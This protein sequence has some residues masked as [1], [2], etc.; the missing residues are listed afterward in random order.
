MATTSTIVQANST[1]PVK[2]PVIPLIIAVVLGVL[3]SVSA[4]SGLGYYLI[5]SGKL[6]LQTASSVQAAPAVSTKTYAVALE[7]MVVNLAD[8]SSGAY[9]RLSMTL[10]VADAADQPAKEEKSANKQADAALR[11]TAL[12]VLVRQTSE[13]LLAADGK[14]QL[15]KE[16]RAALA[17]HN[18][19]VKVTDL[20]ITEFLVQ[21]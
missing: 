4:V 11:D 21:R 18:P 13:S 15:K 10:N 3:V 5:H 9:L 17:E 2:L 16:L 8:G 20:F 1:E 7:P 19:D 12:T 6:K 14:E